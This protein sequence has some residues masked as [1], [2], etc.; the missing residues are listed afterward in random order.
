M[1]KVIAIKLFPDSSFIYK[2]Q[3]EKGHGACPE[4]LA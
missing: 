2:T 3:I 4:S 1:A